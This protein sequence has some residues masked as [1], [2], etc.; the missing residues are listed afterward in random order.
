MLQTAQA[1]APMIASMCLRLERLF[2]LY[3]GR[4][5]M[6]YL[7]D[8]F[9]LRHATS[10]LLRK[11][12]VK[13]CRTLAAHLVGAHAQL[14]IGLLFVH[15]RNQS[16]LVLLLRPSLTQNLVLVYSFLLNHIVF[17]FLLARFITHQ[18]RFFEGA[19]K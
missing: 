1:Q 4:C 15:L 8:F 13:N 2:K 17:F 11:S 18:R 5:E 14:L 3:F 10:A 6:E 19:R 9:A 16:F 7:L 12:P